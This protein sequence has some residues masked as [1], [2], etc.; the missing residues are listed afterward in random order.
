MSWKDF[1]FENS[2]AKEKAPDSSKNTKQEML[3]QNVNQAIVQPQPVIQVQ[4][5]SPGVTPVGIISQE[6]FNAFNDVLKS[7]DLPIPN[8][9][10]VKYASDSLKSSFPDDNTRFGVAFNTIK[11]ASPSLTKKVMTDSI[12][13][14]IGRME[15]EHDESIKEFNERVEIEV[16]ARQKTIDSKKTEIEANAKEIIEL[17]EKNA[18]LSGDINT[19]GGEMQTKQIELDIQ[20]KNFEATYEAYMVNLKSDSVKIETLIIE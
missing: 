20:K 16:T 7:L 19:I 5:I 8:Y 9:L 12:N 15:F 6:I 3:T 17:Q 11:A 1:L 13:K 2:D 18:A 14:C 10:G 4:Q